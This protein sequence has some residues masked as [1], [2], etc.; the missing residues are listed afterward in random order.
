MRTLIYKRTHIGDPDPEEGVFGC[1]DCMGSVRGS[2]FDAAIGIGGI[3]SEAK[4][5]GI[6]RRLTWIGLGKHEIVRD[7]SRSFVSPRCPLVIFDHFLYYEKEGPLLEDFAAALARR[8]YDGRVRHLKHFPS[9]ATA[10]LDW[11]VQKI[12]EL[13][14]DAP[15]SRRLSARDLQHAIG[16]CRPKPRD[17]R[18][19]D[20]CQSSKRRS[21]ADRL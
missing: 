1:N 7:P 12:L 15:P 6:A 19:T 14:M 4:R 16:K 10:R 13:A 17:V 21:G 8:M 2:L 20:A 9:P 11:D 3:G 18:I 5:N